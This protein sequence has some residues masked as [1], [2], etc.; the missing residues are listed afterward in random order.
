MLER[1]LVN[2]SI[3]QNY[4]DC[5]WC[6]VVAMDACHLLLGKQ[7]QYERKV[8]HNGH[9]NTYSFMLNSTRIVLLKDFSKLIP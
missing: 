3:G 9:L 5:A 2:F 4:K 1:R 7:W 6:D 8:T